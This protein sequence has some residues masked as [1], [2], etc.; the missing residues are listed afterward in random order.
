[1]PP[2]LLASILLQYRKGISEE[3]LLQKISCLGMALTRRGAIVTN[4]GGLPNESTLKLGLK[5][6]NDYIVKK[7][8]FYMPKV[9]G[10]DY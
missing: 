2:V 4:D 5:H 8:N 6:L 9:V 10:N 3:K 1:M 7:R